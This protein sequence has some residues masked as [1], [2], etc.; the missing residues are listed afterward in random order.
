MEG[1]DWSILIYDMPFISSGHSH[2]QKQTTS[3]ALIVSN[4][5]EH[6]MAQ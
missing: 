3:A 6:K 5:S 1:D 2:V 4:E